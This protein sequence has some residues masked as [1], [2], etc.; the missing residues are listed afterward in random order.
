MTFLRNFWNDEQGQDLIEY[1]L[2]MAFVA[3][4]SAALFL[5]AG[6]S[7]KGIWTTTNSQ[8]ASRQHVGQ[9][10]CREGMRRRVH[11]RHAPPELWS[12]SRRPGKPAGGL[13]QD[14]AQQQDWPRRA[15]GGG[16]Q[17]WRTRCGTARISSAGFGDRFPAAGRSRRSREADGWWL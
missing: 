9:L 17:A 13:M 10:K 11:A 7:I 15:R 2:L 8:L 14:K 16:K 6:G 12:G 3:L 4:A 1:T 5:G